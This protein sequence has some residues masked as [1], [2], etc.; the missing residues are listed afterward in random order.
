[1]EIDSP[2]SNE[3]MLHR[4]V[5]SYDTR[6]TDLTFREEIRAGVLSV[7]PHANGVPELPAD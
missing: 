5:A 7:R 3:A 4:I 2:N 1:M 6:A